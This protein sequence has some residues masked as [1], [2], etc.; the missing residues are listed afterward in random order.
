M[1]LCSGSPEHLRRG[2]SSRS[3]AHVCARECVGRSE[4]HV[5]STALVCTC[6]RVPEDECVNV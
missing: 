3:L 1:P 6:R 2:T 4:L 5:V